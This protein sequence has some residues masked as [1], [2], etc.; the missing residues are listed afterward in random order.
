[1]LYALLALG[2]VMVVGVV[3]AL[4]AAHRAPVGYEDETGFHY[5]PDH[6]GAKEQDFDP[7]LGAVIH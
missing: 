5:G 3:S 2:V 1:M 7:A 6:A 4:W